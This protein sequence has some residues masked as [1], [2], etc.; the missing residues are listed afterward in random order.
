MP[1]ISFVIFVL[2]QIVFV[3][4]AFPGVLLVAYRQM[5]VSKK[6][7]ISQTAIEVLNGRWTMH[8]FGM[9]DDPATARLASVLPNTSLAGLWLVLFPLW[10]KYKLSGQLFMYPRVPE[11]GRENIANMMI[12]RTS[13]FD[14]IIE[15]RIDEVEQFVVLGAGYDTRAYGKFNREGVT[16]FELDQSSIQA[17]KRKALVDAGIDA[18]HVRFATVN[19]EAENAFDKLIEAGYDPSKKTLFLWEGVTLYL[20]EAD[21]RKMMTDIHAHA[22]PGSVLLADI[23]AD[24]FLKIGKNKLGE[25][26]LDYTSEGLVFGLPFDGDYRTTLSD[27]IESEGMSVGKTH[28]MGSASKKGPFVAVVEMKV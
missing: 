12:A 21:V 4:L 20:S 7:G 28:F 19:F 6:L 1:F 14:E 22:A 5:V 3:P 24:R 13:Y 27:F 8:A 23:Y 15:A 25:K 11:E 9:R 2:L 10:V 18:D 16:F 26:A 17:H